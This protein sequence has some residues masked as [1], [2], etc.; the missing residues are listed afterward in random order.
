MIDNPPTHGWVKGV[1]TVGVT[2]AKKLFTRM[3]YVA[4][5][6]SVGPA[7][8]NLFTDTPGARL[9]W[10]AKQPRD[11]YGD[12]LVST[13]ADA[14]ICVANAGVT[15]RVVRGFESRGVPALGPIWDS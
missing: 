12:A 7:P 14:V 10:V 3:L 15:D 4:T 5:G 11:T 13:G 8:G 1:P 2:T 9:V 6:S